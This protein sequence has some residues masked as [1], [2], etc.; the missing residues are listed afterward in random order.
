[1]VKLADT[2]DLGSSAI[3]CRFKS[4]HPYQ[5]NAMLC[6]A[7]F[8]SFGAPPE[9]RRRVQRTCRNSKVGKFICKTK[10]QS[11]KRSSPCIA[12]KQYWLFNLRWERKSTLIECAF[13][14]THRRFELRT[15]ALKVRC[16]TGWASESFGRG[17]WIWTNECQN[18][19]LVPYRLAIPLSSAVYNIT[20]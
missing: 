11:V 3:A 15:I 14:V 4:C 18:Q 1:M 8:L 7:F 17:S 5:R 6:I 19:N 9:I 12:R 10:R 2:L 16:S 13:L 20:S